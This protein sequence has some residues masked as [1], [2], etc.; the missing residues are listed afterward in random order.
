MRKIPRFLPADPKALSRL[1]LIMDRLFNDVTPDY[2]LMARLVHV[3]ERLDRPTNR[4]DASVQNLDFAFNGP[5]ADVPDQLA[6]LDHEAFRRFAGPARHVGLLVVSA[7]IQVRGNNKADNEALATQV[8]GM[9]REGHVEL[10]RSVKSSRVIAGVTTDGWQLD[11]VRDQG[12]EKPRAVL[13]SPG[14]SWRDNDLLPV[15]GSLS[16]QLRDVMLHQPDRFTMDPRAYAE[17]SAM[18]MRIKRPASNVD[19]A[20]DPVQLV[21]SALIEAALLAAL[22]AER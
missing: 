2:K 18:P 15:L 1:A 4:I 12:A 5:V 8:R 20:E 7:C 13:C 17:R 11:L 6:M 3:V 21:P 16:D 9:V 10:P 14:E 22:R 19:Q